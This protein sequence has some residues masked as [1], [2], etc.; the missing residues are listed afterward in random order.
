MSIVHNRPK[1]PL[2]IKGWKVEQL[3][4]GWSSSEVRNLLLPTAINGE[5]N[6]KRGVWTVNPTIRLSCLHMALFYQKAQS[7]NNCASIMAMFGS[8]YQA[9]KKKVWI[10]NDLQN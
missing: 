9:K 7:F 5:T 4:M 6:G 3:D 1:I 8:K 2:G 10:E